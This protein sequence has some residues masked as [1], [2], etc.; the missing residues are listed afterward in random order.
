MN[1]IKVK[2]VMTHLVVTTLETDPIQKAAGL[3]GRNRISGAPVI[4]DRKVVGVVSEADLARALVSPANIDHG[5]GTADVLSI[6]L[7]A[8][9]TR[10]QHLR[11]VADV[12]TSPAITIGTDES[13]FAAARKMER[14]GLKRLPVTDA[15]G[16]LL[17]IIS[18]ADLI[19]AMTRS[20]TEI[21]REVVDAIEVLGPENLGDLEVS[22]KDGIVTLTGGC[23]R[24]STRDI[25]VSIASRVPGVSE[26]VDRLE[27]DLDDTA[28]HPFPHSSPTD[29]GPD[30]WAV[31]PLVKG[32]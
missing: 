23:D 19:R 29:I 1:E 12:M 26:V 18:R 32:V 22:V 31:G 15:G 10:H 20:D 9:P 2:D 30:P 3:L 16:F 13:L 24:R 28:V 11:T 4:R 6:I 25:A 17:G 8:A 7:K 5:L 21:G 14:H 27:Y